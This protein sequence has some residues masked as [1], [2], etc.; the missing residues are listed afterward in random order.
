MTNEAK[1]IDAAI[2][3]AVEK[4]GYSGFAGN[5]ARFAV[6]L[7]R[8]LGGSGTYV[9]ADSGEHYEYVDHVALRFN[10]QL[11]DGEGALTMRRLRSYGSKVE[12]VGDDLGVLRLADEGCLGDVLDDEALERDLREALVVERSKGRRTR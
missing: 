11:Y 7:N 3:A 4:G 12:D 1:T 9:L 10:G 6:V 2:R 8:V 5:C